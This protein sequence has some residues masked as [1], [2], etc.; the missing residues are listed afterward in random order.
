MVT[1]SFVSGSPLVSRC[2]PE[3]EEQRVPDVPV[4]DD[5]VPLVTRAGREDVHD[6]LASV[7]RM[8]VRA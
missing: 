8:C 6:V 2:C 1:R 5:E 3:V 4:P 7:A